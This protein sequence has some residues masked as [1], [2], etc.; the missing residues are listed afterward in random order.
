M[1]ILFAISASLWAFIV[2][3]CIAFGPI[4]KTL[5]WKPNMHSQTWYRLTPI[6]CGLIPHTS[7]SN[8]PLWIA[9]ANIF[10]LLVDNTFIHS[11][12]TLKLLSEHLIVP[13]FV[14]QKHNGIGP[15]ACC[16]AT[17]SIGLL[18][19]IPVEA[20][21]GQIICFVIQMWIVYIQFYITCVHEIV[22]ELPEA[23]LR[24][25]RMV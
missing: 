15:W 2:A 20:Q 23:E 10:T 21:A 9:A 8:I 22:R 12:G 17:L 4:Q 1:R 3:R 25:A 16:N 6:K 7:V 18:F 13:I 14:E 24:Q 5:Q 19:F 11:I